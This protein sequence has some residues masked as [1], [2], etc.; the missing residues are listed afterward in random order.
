MNTATSLRDKLYD[1]IRVADDKKLNAIYNLL[2]N[3]ITDTK[4]WWKDKQFVA[5][6]DSRY[7]AMEKGTDKGFTVEQ[8]ETSITKLRKNKYGK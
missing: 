5:E 3:E 7:A 2:E 1:Y 8:L 6:L 4:E